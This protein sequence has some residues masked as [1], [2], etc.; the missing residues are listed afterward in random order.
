MA[1]TAKSA[2]GA[3]MKIRTWKAFCFLVDA[4]DVVLSIQEPLQA[5]TQENFQ[6]FR[7][8]E[9][10][11]H[12]QAWNLTTMASMFRDGMLR[13]GMHRGWVFCTSIL[14]DGTLLIRPRAGP[15]PLRSWR[16]VPRTS[17]DVPE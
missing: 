7:Q 11:V 12:A 10:S 17:T 1:R 16:P 6:M 9:A 3:Y 8:V 4:S 15:P 5:Q 2:W 13:N 14:H